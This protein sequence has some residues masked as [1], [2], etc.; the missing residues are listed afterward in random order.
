[1]V[2]ALAFA[3]VGGAAPSGSADLGITKADSPDPRQPGAAAD[4]PYYSP[5]A[6][7]VRLDPGCARRE[8]PTSLMRQIG[9]VDPAFTL[10]V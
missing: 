8:D 9:H 10:R 6:P 3:G 4:G 1:V 2:S 5:A 7:R